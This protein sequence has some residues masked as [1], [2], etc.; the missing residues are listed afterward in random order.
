MKGVKLMHT[1]KEVIRLI[2]KIRLQKKMSIESLAKKVGIAKS[3]L[4]RYENEERDFPINDVGKFADALNTSV[5]Y[6]L[7]LNKTKNVNSFEYHYYPTS[8]SAGVPLEVDGMTNDDI[9]KISLP[10]TVMG[11]WAGNK[12][13]YITRVNGE[14][15]NKII[16]DQ[17]LIAVKP[18]EL[19]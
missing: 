17:S 16:P 4:S 10:D 7:G 3:T 5:E 13:I 9:Q 14:S 1:S 8:I 6:L 12:D 2:K 15:M 18:V 11:K 19:S